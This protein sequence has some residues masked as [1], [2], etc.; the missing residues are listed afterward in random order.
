MTIFHKVALLGKGT[1]GSLL[2]DELLKAQFSVTVL[3]RSN[4]TTKE[5]PSTTRDNI[6]IKQVDYTSVESLK[7]ALQGHEI[8]ISTLTPTAIPL[9]KPIIDACIAAGVKRF[10]PADYGAITCDPSGRAQKLPF[11]AAAVGIQEYLRE[12]ESQ[13][14]H[15]IFAVGAFLERI[16]TMPVAVDFPRRAVTLY[17]DGVHGFSVSRAVTVARAIVRAIQRPE[18]TKNRVVRVHDAVLTQRKVYDLARK[19]TAGQEW[20]ETNVNAQEQLG[21]TLASLQK[22]FNPALLPA[23][24]IA[25]IFSGKYGAEYKDG[26]LDNELLGLGVM[27]DDE[28]ER[29]GLALNPV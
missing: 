26:D 27:S 19:W 24:F 8:V 22:G 21:S 2:L 17:D 7:S 1:L 10:I 16:F 14:E 3:T 15:T 20:T 11:N 29:F 28:V 4:P 13:I 5:T 18:E 12:R 9:Q 25:A 6:T 23:I